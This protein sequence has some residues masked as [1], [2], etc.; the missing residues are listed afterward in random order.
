MLACRSP[1]G[2]HCFDAI[3]LALDGGVN[4]GAKSPGIVHLEVQTD[5]CGFH[6][7]NSSRVFSCTLYKPRDC[8][9]ICVGILSQFLELYLPRI[10]A[11]GLL[12]CC[13]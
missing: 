9:Y 2:E 4:E 5:V 3:K 1:T 8:K 12:A 13:D 7:E 6:T 10:R 11:V